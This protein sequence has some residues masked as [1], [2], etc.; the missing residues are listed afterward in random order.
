MLGYSEADLPTWLT[1]KYALPMSHTRSQG[2][3]RI[4]P[5]SYSPAKLERF[6]SRYTSEMS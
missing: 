1:P 2:G 3:I 6:T 5:G 4:D